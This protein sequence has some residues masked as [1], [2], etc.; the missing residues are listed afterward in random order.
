MRKLIPLLLAITFVFACKTSKPP[1]A[2]PP[3]P[4]A[5]VVDAAALTDALG[6]SL[7]TAV[8]VPASAAS[9]EGARF[10]KQWIYDRYGK[11]HRRFSG[12]VSENGRHY[13]EI[14]VELFDHSERVVYFDIT[15]VYGATVNHTTP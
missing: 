12:V 4:A 8:P 14:T 5:T 3:G 6:T 9:D 15:D 13:D 11:F 10:E 2:P 1:K 7:E